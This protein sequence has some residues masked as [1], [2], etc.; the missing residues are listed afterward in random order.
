[1]PRSDRPS[2]GNRA[3]GDSN[4][5]SRQKAGY[6]AQCG[7]LAGAVGADHRDDAARRNFDADAL[8]RRRDVMIDNFKLAYVEQRSGSFAIARPP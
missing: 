4:V 1:M 5:F 8:H 6:G 3:V 2:E 7:R